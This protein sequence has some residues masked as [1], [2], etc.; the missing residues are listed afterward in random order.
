MTLMLEDQRIC[1]LGTIILAVSYY[2]L[3]F[4]VLCIYKVGFF[5][6]GGL[7]FFFLEMIASMAFKNFF[8]MILSDIL[9]YWRLLNKWPHINFSLAVS[10]FS[11]LTQSSPL[12]SY[13]CFPCFSERILSQMVWGVEN[14]Q[15]TSEPSQNPCVHV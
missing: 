2:F 5:L 10:L 12:S 11:L 9:I 6:G 14:S 1:P 7:G 8:N 13:P 3:L 15:A 4:S